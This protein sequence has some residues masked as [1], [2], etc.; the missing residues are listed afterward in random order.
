MKGE[1]MISI[2]FFLITA[3]SAV[4]RKPEPPALDLRELDLS[5]DEPGFVYQWEVCT[6]KGLFGKCREWSITKEVY[7][8]ND[9][10]VRKKLYYMNFVGTVREKPIQP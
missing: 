8:L 2:V 9:P 1:I 7:D 3:C 5:L 4:E 6:K 10:E